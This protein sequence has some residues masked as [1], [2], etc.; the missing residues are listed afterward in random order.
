MPPCRFRTS[1]LSRAVVLKDICRELATTDDQLQLEE[2]AAAI[3]SAMWSHKQLRP[4]VDWPIARLYRM[5]GI[6]TELFTPLF[7]VA[8]VAGWSAHVLEQQRDNRLIAPRA[9][10]IGVQPRSFVPLHERG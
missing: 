4:N 1:R 7:V 9:K 8:R 5:L 3:E 10:Y 2:I 6:E